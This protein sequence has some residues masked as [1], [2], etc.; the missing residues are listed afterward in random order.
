MAAVTGPP[1]TV[2]FGRMSSGEMEQ[3]LR[4]AGMEMAIEILV[5]N[6][7]QKALGAWQAAAQKSAGLGK[8]LYVL[9][10]D[11]APELQ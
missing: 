10:F 6:P 5:Q 2:E 1:G 4:R 8:H 9:F 11:T 3:N 7:R